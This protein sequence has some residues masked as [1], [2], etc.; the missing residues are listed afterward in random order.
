MLALI[1]PV[2]TFGIIRSLLRVILFM[3]VSC[4][5]PSR[6][7]ISNYPPLDGEGGEARSSRA[8]PGGVKPQGKVTLVGYPH[9]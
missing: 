5:A 6:A 2:V 9:P 7:A 1:G 8:E 4:C 3:T